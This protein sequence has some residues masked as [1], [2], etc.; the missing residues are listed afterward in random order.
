MNEVIARIL[1]ADP[2]K[3]DALA[4][5]MPVQ[6]VEAIDI[7]NAIAWLVSDEARYVS[8]ICLPVDAGFTAK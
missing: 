1:E 2:T 5:L 3:A 7:S 8:G 4:N 6:V